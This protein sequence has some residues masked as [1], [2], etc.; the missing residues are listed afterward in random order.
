MANT[1][2]ALSPLAYAALI[3]SLA[4]LL[5]SCFYR[6]RITYTGKRSWLA[7]IDGGTLMLLRSDTPETPNAGW[8]YAHLH[9]DPYAG[10]LDT[11]GGFR[12][13][14]FHLH[15]AS[16]PPAA[17]QIAFIRLPLWM[18]AA[19]LLALALWRCR[20]FSARRRARGFEPIV[21]QAH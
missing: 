14:G 8:A 18:I 7:E 11:A 9:R 15:P 2:R 10:E 3:L 21:D 12:L 20:Q 13:L 17:W 6:E 4:A 16:S 19:P 1:R 5:W